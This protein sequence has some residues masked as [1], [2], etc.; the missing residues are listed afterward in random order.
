M[1]LL[2]HAGIKVKTMLVKGATGLIIQGHDIVSVF[3]SSEFLWGSFLKLAG[4][5]I[6]A[7]IDKARIHI[8]LVHLC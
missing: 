6:Y 3:I 7:A 8:P 5:D 2:I 1:W 4:S